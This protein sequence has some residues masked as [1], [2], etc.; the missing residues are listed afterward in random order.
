MKTK[1]LLLLTLCLPLCLFAQSIESLRGGWIAGKGTERHIYYIVLRDN[2]VSGF[3]CRDCE[4]PYNLAFIDDGSLDADGLRFSLYHYPQDAGPYRE[5]VFAS[6]IG[7]ELGLD[8]KGPQGASRQ[9]ILHRTRPEDQVRLPMPD[10]SPNRPAGA[11][12]P[13]ARTL[14][15]PAE[16]ISKD[17]VLGLWLWGTGPGKQHFIFREHKGG[18][19]GMV[20]GPCDSAPD[21]APLEGISMD[22]T[23]FHFEIVHED[24]GLDYEKHGPH[25]NVT[26]ARIAEHEMHMNVIPSFE[27]PDFKPIEMTLLGPIDLD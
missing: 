7:T 5:E 21:T 10:A 26:D 19:R 16:V 14:P 22:G 4:N 1:L 23:N 24:N 15:G 11:G 18:V 8:I 25:S 27:G 17:K 12:R 20:C 3:Y 2:K 13:V 9:L 6:L